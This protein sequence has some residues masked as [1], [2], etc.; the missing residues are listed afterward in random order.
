M[1]RKHIAILAALTGLSAPVFAADVSLVVY[2][3]SKHMGSFKRQ[4]NEVNWGLGVEVEQSGWLVGAGAYRDSYYEPAWQAY[5]GY[6]WD[7][8]VAARTSVVLSLKAGY[9]NGSGF[10]GP[11]AY[12]TLG[13]RFGPVVVEGTVF[14]MRKAD[15]AVG[16]IWARYVF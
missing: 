12:P 11:V 4:F 8:P 7:F 10:H 16:A 13:V 1:K 15:G 9:L 2:G 14:P 6:R 3:L 5:A